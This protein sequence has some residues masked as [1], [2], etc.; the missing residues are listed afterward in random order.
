ML[1]TVCLKVGDELQHLI[2]PPDPSPAGVGIGVITHDFAAE[3]CERG[4]QLQNLKIM[5]RSEYLMECG[6][7]QHL[8]EQAKQVRVNTNTARQSVGVGAEVWTCRQLPQTADI[9]QTLTTPS[10]RDT[11]SL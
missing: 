1:A 6:R 7:L 2:Q 10:D 3:V 8:K 4:S 9:L 11:D 5:R